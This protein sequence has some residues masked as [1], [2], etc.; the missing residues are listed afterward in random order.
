MSH[1]NWLALKLLFREAIDLPRED[2]NAFCDANCDSESMKA[3]L[4]QLLRAHE[5]DSDFLEFPVSE[6][7]DASS[8][9]LIG[10]KLGAFTLVRR[11][12]SGGMGVVFEAAQEEPSRRVAIKLLQPGRHHEKMLWRF[13]HESEI[14][15]RMQHRGVAQVYASG[16]DDLGGGIQPWFAMELVGGLPLHRHI[17]KYDLSVNEK[18]EML[19]EISEAVQHAHLRGVIHRDLKPANILI[20]TTSSGSESVERFQPKILD[21]GVARIVEDDA[22]LNAT[23]QTQVGEVIGTITYMS[24]ERFTR[25]PKDVDHRCDVYSLGVIGYEMLTGKLPIQVSSSHIADVLR[26]VETDD[27]I[28]LGKVDTK[29]RNDLEVIFAKTLEKDPERRYATAHDLSEDVRRFMAN[30]PIH[31][32][33]ASTAYRFR[34]LVRRNRTLF[35]GIVATMLALLLGIFFYAKEAKQARLEAANSQYE[36][37]KA[38]AINNFMTNDFFMKLLAVAQRPIDITAH[39]S[40]SGNAAE[41]AE[42]A[43]A[44]LEPVQRLPVKQ[45]IDEASDNVS[46]MFGDRPVI[47]AAVRNEVGTLHYNVGAFDKAAE[48]FKMALD[49]WEAALGR[50]HPDTLKGV[51]NWALTL[52]RQ[53]HGEEAE[54]LY[55]RALEGRRRVLG[56]G[57]SDTLATMNNLAELFR[58]TGRIDDSERMLREA[59]RLQIDASGPNDKQTLT[60]MANLGSILAHREAYDEAAAIHQT[61]FERTNATL[62]HN[63]I[64]S[65]RAG[66]RYAQTLY[67]M[68][69]Y[70]RAKA[71][72]DPVLKSFESIHGRSHIDSITTRRL[73][74]RIARNMGD[75][76]TAQV[77]L[78]IALQAAQAGPQSLTGLI[79]KIERDIRSL[80]K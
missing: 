15:A 24:P 57:D 42:P 79:G 76:A 61:V 2:Q 54:T 51:N 21:F 49:L 69:D 35:A 31:A 65:L 6:H 41:T 23:L 74:A 25:D 56:V 30:E 75:H 14:L 55:R 62:G 52:A 48:Q 29:F 71:T 34:K 53:G 45:L 46:Q 64:T 70:E 44:R 11:L 50:E 58:A 3:E 33:P 12:G 66:S 20:G 19:L 37:D 68:H 1:Q 8:S 17:E 4:K 32:R 22:S 7:D 72:L 77:H 18:L 40:L 63:H 60:V 47:E 26:A 39:N 10:K 43:F 36:A 67:R 78:G 59:L 73:M 80:D 16:V 5:P 13:R 28:P 9:P 27:P 38:K